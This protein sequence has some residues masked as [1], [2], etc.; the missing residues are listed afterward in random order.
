MWVA[1]EMSLIKSPLLPDMSVSYEAYSLF[2]NSVDLSHFPGVI[3]S[4]FESSSYFV[5]GNSHVIQ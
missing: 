5:P 3:A 1:K 2:V 4:L